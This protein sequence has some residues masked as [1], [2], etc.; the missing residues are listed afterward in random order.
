MSEKLLIFLGTCLLSFSITSS[1]QGNGALK[2]EDIAAQA[3]ELIVRYGQGDSGVY[4]RMANT[5]DDRLVP[6]FLEAL[7][8]S[9]SRIKILARSQLR[10]YGKKETIVPM[11]ELLKH[12]ENADVRA[13]AAAS[14]ARFRTAES[15]QDLLNALHDESPRVVRAAIRVLGHLKSKEAVVPLKAR[16]SIDNE[17]NWAVRRAAKDA[18][19]SI[20]GADWKRSMREIPPQF[21][22][23]NEDITHQAYEAAME[24]LGSSALGKINRA[25]SIRELSVDEEFLRDYGKTVIVIEGYYLKQNAEIYR[26]AL[27]NARLSVELG[28]MTNDDVTK[29]EATYN[30]AQSRY[31]DFLAN[32]VWAD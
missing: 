29:A 7:K 11:V 26:K 28:E 12:D 30:Q 23:R 1:I 8:N 5:R 24:N 2:G 21:R 18:L 25:G 16:L 17:K 31:E 13:A 9:N 27:E 14:L 20:I 22:A 32:S 19:E 4:Y 6:V 15:S 3:R 10:K